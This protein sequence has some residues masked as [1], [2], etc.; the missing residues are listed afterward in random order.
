VHGAAERFHRDLD[1]AVHVVH[2][3]V[4]HDADHDRSVL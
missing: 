4:D 2:H 3:F 1:V